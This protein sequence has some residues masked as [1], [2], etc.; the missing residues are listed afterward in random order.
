MKIVGKVLYR[1]KDIEACE[2][3]CLIRKVLQMSTLKAQNGLEN[4]RRALNRFEIVLA[5]QEGWTSKHPS[6]RRFSELGW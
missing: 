4:A 3:A 2:E 5:E 1:V 6:V